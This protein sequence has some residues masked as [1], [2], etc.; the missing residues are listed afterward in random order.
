VLNLVRAF[1]SSTRADAAAFKPESAWGTIVRFAAFAMGCWLL[2]AVRVH[3]E[4]RSLA[5]PLNTLILVISLV[6]LVLAMQVFLQLR[7]SRTP[8][9]L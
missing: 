7:R 9:S 8:K 5:E 3:D 1:G 4:L 2:L 6:S